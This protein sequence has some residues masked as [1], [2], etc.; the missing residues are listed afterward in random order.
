M[1]QGRA[2]MRQR[3]ID[4]SARTQLPKAGLEQLGQRVRE[5]Q[6]SKENLI[7]AIPKLAGNILTGPA[8]SS[9]I[10]ARHVSLL[11]QYTDPNWLKMRELDHLQRIY[12]QLQQKMQFKK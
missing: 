9:A 2:V 7:E 11:R 1:A 12:D 5:G 4:L 8:G 6:I 10:A 3:A